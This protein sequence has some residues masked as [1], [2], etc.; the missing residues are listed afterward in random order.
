MMQGEMFIAGEARR[1]T[2]APVR[3]VNPAT[4]ETLEPAFGGA[5]KADLDAACAAAEAA[6]DTYRSLPADARAAFLESIAQNI[7][8]LGDSLIERTMTE[9]GLPR[10]RLEGER[11]RTVGQLRMFAQVVRDG[12]YQ[13]LRVDPADPA[14]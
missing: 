3:A 10:P 12:R 1:G 8:D 4:G 14:R 6:F 5:T 9:T 11:G 13:D 7:L 2:A